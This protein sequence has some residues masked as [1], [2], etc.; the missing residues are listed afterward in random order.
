MFTYC[1]TL[2]QLNRKGAKQMA[3]KTTE[4]KK[5]YN[6]LSACGY[7]ACNVSKGNKKLVPN[8]DTAFIIWNLPAIKTCPYATEAC[9]AA[10]YARKAEKAYPQV[11]PARNKN[12]AESMQDDFVFRM[13]YT[14]LKIRK[15]TSKKTVIVRIHESG[16]FYNKAYAGKWLRVMAFCAGED[17]QFIAYTKSFKYFDG[18]QLPASFA[19]RASVWDDTKPEQLDIISRNKWAIYTAVDKFTE[20]DT[21]EQCRCEDCATCGKC[22]NISLK[23]IRCEIH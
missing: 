13:V 8:K 22:W 9:K 17:I 7:T 2:E 23:D 19:L 14:I 5:L 16:D 20:A 3:L 12:F 15:G 4:A 1:G 11:L 10:C 6:E 18:V 21:F